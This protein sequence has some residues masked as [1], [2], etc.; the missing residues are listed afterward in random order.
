MNASF[1][2]TNKS[3]FYQR[4]S[5]VAFPFS[6]KAHFS[7]LNTL[8]KKAGKQEQVCICIIMHKQILNKEGESDANTNNGLHNMLD[9]KLYLAVPFSVQE[10]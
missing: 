8:S 6:N 5:L 7:A 2:F 10:F 9:I 3:D 1:S 4:A